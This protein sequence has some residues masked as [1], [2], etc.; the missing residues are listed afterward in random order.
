[1]SHIKINAQDNEYDLRYNFTPLIKLII[2]I[3]D[4]MANETITYQ[5]ND[6]QSKNFDLRTEVLK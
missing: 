1:M 2:K 5:W 4:L 6:G 3:I